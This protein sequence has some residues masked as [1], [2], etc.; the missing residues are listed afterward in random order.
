MTDKQRLFITEY[1]KDLNATQ[2]AI[3]AGYSEDSARSIGQENLTKPDI[4]KAIQERIEEI[5]GGSGEYLAMLIQY[6][7]SVLTQ[8]EDTQANRL[9]ASELLGKHIGAFTDRVKLSGDQANPIDVNF[10]IH[11][12]K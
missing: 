12:A 6:W 11:R 7:T 5:T 3:R 8:D 10:V 4:K 2:A 1:L 9:K